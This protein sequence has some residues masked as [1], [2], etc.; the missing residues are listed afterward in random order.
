MSDPIREAFAYDRT[1]EGH[2]PEYESDEG[3]AYEYFERGWQA[4]LAW[5]E[6]EDAKR[7]QE[8]M[9]RLSREAMQITTC[10]IEPDQ[11]MRA[12][13]QQEYDRGAD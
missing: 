3:F 11:N 10:R 7:T 1:W 12:I 6:R 2:P 9:D 5:R 13:N 8:T 4:A